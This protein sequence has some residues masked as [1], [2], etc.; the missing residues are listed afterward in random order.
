M[1]TNNYN[2]ETEKTMQVLDA[3]TKVKSSPFFI[4][5]LEARFD[6]KQEANNYSIHW[7]TSLKYAFF[8]LIIALNVIAS[9]SYINGGNSKKETRESMIQELSGTYF[10]T[11]SNSNSITFQ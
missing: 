9:Y 1:K 3:L 10:S 11:S 7:K 4:T 8:I 2:E 6:K 5:R